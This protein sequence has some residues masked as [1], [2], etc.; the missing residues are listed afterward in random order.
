[1][2]I[3]NI[4]CWLKDFIFIEV[5]DLLLS[6]STPQTRSFRQNATIRPEIDN[7]P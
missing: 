4:E 3:A 6:G 5:D 2:V 1:M 7:M